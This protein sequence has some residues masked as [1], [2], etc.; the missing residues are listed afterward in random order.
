MLDL[1]GPGKFVVVSEPRMMTHAEIARAWLGATLI[2]G[3]DQEQFD[4][5][6]DAL[7][8]NIGTAVIFVMIDMQAEIEARP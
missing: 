1:P 2:D 7:P 8:D 3:I 5:E 4:A 6:L